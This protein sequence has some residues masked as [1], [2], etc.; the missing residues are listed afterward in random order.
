M[1]ISKTAQV[2]LFVALIAFPVAIPFLP[3]VNGLIIVLLSLAGFYLLSR[4]DPVI[5]NPDKSERQLYTAIGVFLLSVAMVAL[6]ADGKPFAETSIGKFIYFALIIPV[7]F[8]AKKLGINRAALWSGLAAGALVS[9]VVAIY[10]VAGPYHMERAMG[11][12]H[13]IIF[14]DLALLMGVMAMGGLTWFR[15]QSRWHVLI[16]VLALVA[17]LLASFLSQSRGGWVALPVLALLFVW[18]FGVHVARWKIL[19]GMALLLVFVTG[20]YFVP[21]SGVRNTINT[22]IMHVDNYVNSDVSAPDRATS[23]G[24]RFEMW[25]ASWILFI[26]H[27]VLGVGWGKYQEETQTLVNRGLINQAAAD[28]PHP[29]NQFLSSLVNGG[30]AGLVGI[31]VLFIIM[32]LIFLRVIKNGAEETS[33]K[34][35]IAFTGLLLVVSFF[36]FNLS[37]SL[38]ERSRT[39]AFMVYYVAILLACIT[40]KGVGNKR[41]P[42]HE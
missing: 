2:L 23:I 21:Q 8:C 4:R 9:A 20:I 7:Y 25:R 30:M 12:N 10:D 33:D 35:H 11:I 5:S 34:S 32:F 24:S 39:V 15:K 17:G 26:E 37:E 40:A 3:H 1:N 14:G 27:P 28:Y 19:A 31:L 38:M 41:A 18:H 16:P 6:F 36:I 42:A 29:H 13:P 22:T